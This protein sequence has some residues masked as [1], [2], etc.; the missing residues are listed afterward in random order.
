MRLWSDQS[1]VVTFGVTGV[2]GIAVGPAATPLATR[3]SRWKGFAS[4]EDLVN[5]S[6]G[7]LLMGFGGMR[8]RLYDRLGLTGI[9]TA[10]I[11]AL[12]AAGAIVG[13]S[14]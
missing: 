2:L 6:V 9:S 8:A 11:G 13:L 10:A 7:G 4:T 12:I 1:R 14:G 5:H 3:T